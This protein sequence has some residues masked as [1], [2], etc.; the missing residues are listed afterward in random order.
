MSYPFVH[1]KNHQEDAQRFRIICGNLVFHELIAN[2]NS[3]ATQGVHQLCVV[4]LKDQGVVSFSHLVR[5]QKKAEV[6]RNHHR[7]SSKFGVFQHK[8]IDIS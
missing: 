4:Q 2:G 5:N 6:G 8:I 3:G 7:I 1:P